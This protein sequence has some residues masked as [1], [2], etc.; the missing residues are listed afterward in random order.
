V[1][2]IVTR[3]AAQAGP[4]KERLEALGH[5]VV[6]CPLIEIEPLSDDP[7]DTSGYDWVIVTSPNGARELARRQVG[8]LWSVAAI[9]P[10]TAAAL[11]E[12]GI[13]PD[14]TAETSTQEG[15]AEAFPLRPRRALFA[16]GEGARRLLADELG[17]EFL[18]LYRTVELEPA[19]PPAGDV[20]V[21]ASASAARAFGRLGLDIP[22]V[23][24]GPET[25]RA[26][27]AAG[28][29]V[30]AEAENHDLDGLMDAIASV[31]R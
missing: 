31:S 29:D 5:D 20:V 21:L 3:P 1:K 4:L 8:D 9:G 6:P 13:R 16:G 23:S 22:A 17:A 12:H 14:L 2:V 7:I 15:L 18:P 24:I 30:I 19:V 26:A 28:I 27:R 11:K 10:G 25:S